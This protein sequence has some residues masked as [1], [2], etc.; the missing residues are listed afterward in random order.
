MNTFAIVLATA[1]T[2]T[3]V[4]FLLI[5]PWTLTWGATKDEVARLM[6]GDEVVKTPHFVATRAVT[7]AAPASEV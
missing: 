5:R 2:V 6:M 3:L 1:I 4:Y 7:I